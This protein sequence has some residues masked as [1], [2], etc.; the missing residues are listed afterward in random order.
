MFAVWIGKNF[1]KAQLYWTMK[2]ESELPDLSGSR[3]LLH[4]EERKGGK[5]RKER[6]KGLKEGKKKGGKERKEMKEGRINESTN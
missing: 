4:K 1:P 3:I 2:K 5:G 6:T